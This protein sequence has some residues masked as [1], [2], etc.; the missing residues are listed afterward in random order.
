MVYFELLKLRLNKRRSVLEEAHL[1]Y[2]SFHPPLLRQSLWPSDSVRDHIPEMNTWVPF[3]VVRCSLHWKG[4]D[5]CF[6][7]LKR[8]VGW[9]KRKCHLIISG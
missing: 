3:S 7:F 9:W 2:E 4:L 6:D 1:V 8:A 5:L